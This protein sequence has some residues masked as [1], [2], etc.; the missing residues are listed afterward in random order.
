LVRGPI[1]ARLLIAAGR[2]WTPAAPRSDWLAGA[3]LGFGADTPVGP[4]DASYGVASNGRHALFI[5]LGKWF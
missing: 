2:A 5:R 1:Q 3:R 4:V